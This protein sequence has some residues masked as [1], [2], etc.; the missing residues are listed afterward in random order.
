[1]K[2][3]EYCGQENDDG[4]VACQEC[5]SAFPVATASQSKLPA[6]F[7]FPA[8]FQIDLD[9]VPD[10]FEFHDGFSRPN[11]GYI[12]EAVERAENDLSPRERWEEVVLQ[13]LLRL[14][15][16]MGG[17]Y[18]LSRNKHFLCLTTL[19]RSDA[20]A[21]L[22]LADNSHLEISQ[23][24]G[25]IAWRDTPGP[26]VVVLFEEEDDYFEYVGFFNP[27]DMMSDSLGM[28]L[29]YGYPHIAIRSAG[30]RQD[31]LTLVHELT[32]HCVTHLPI[33]LWLNEGV[34]QRLQRFIVGAYA[35]RESESPTSTYWADV[36][37]WSPRSC[38]ANWPNVITPFGTKI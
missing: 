19:Q 31:T 9:K 18:T 5:G 2:R 36:S 10:A 26:H 25:D 4:R 1:M 17:N 38:G 16:E 28:H 3:C 21:F 8:A 29:D 15:R 6:S 32:H 20:A 13:W 34:A 33:P 22:R 11:W 30:G 23:R 7:S 14:Q 27:Q 37:G 24:L 12:Q 35:P